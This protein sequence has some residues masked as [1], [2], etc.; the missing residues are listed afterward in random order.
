M[1]MSLRKHT[2]LAAMTGAVL[3]I[4]MIAPAAAR[5]PSGAQP[6]ASPLGTQDKGGKD[7]GS[8]HKNDKSDKQKPRENGPG[9]DSAPRNGGH[10][11]QQHDAGQRHHGNL[12]YSLSLPCT[13]A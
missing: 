8:E 3:A 10:Q 1:N 12:R 13:E 9:H 5:Q 11:P 4:S 2:V 7:K 6:D